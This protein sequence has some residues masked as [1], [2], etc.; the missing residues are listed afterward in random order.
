MIAR[1]TNPLVS[2]IVITYNS[3]KYVLETLESAK[4]QTYQNIELIITDDCSTDNTVELC[5][6]WLSV[7]KQR[8]VD[9]EI[10]TSPQNTGIP[11]NCNRGTRAAKGLWIK[12]IAGDD[13]L[14][15]SCIKDNIEFIKK[16]IQAKLVISNVI[17]FNDFGDNR[18]TKLLVPKNIRLLSSTSDSESQY[19]GLLRCFFGLTPSWFINKDLIDEVGCYDERFPFIEDYPFALKATKAGYPFHYLNKVTAYY[20]ES[21]KS[22]YLS[23]SSNNIFNDFYKKKIYFDKEYRFKYLKKR[24]YYCELFEYH[25]KKTIDYFGLNKKNLLC[26]GINVLSYWSN[27]FI[28][29][30]KLF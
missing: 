6:N 17:M 22:V 5:S 11:A 23:K 27:P 1:N 19:T 29:I 25:R 4:A 16:R 8:F 20:R 30:N 21:E 24:E 28:Y 15:T 2:I 14:A 13:L 7:N 18:E 9:T 3:S 26:R 12:F 10:V